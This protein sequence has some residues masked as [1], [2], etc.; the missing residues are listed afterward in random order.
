MACWRNS[1][2]GVLVE[3]D[4]ASLTEAL[5]ERV[6]VGCFGTRAVLLLLLLLL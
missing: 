2:I 3:A 1:C 4:I 6:L 5:F